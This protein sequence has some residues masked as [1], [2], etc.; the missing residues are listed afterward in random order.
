MNS[1]MIGRMLTTTTR[2]K[3]SST[4]FLTNSIF[5]RK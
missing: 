3:I 2:I 1:Q 5:P 4:F